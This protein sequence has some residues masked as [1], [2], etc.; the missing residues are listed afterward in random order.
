ML[1]NTNEVAE[2]EAHALEERRTEICA[3]LTASIC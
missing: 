2:H 1:E 3:V